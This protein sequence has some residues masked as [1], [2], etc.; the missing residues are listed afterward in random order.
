MKAFRKPSLTYKRAKALERVSEE[1]DDRIAKQFITLLL[2]W[3][4][5]NYRY[6]KQRRS[7]MA[8]GRD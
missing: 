1:T 6:E 5:E 7:E 3:Y 4:R 8:K 2:E